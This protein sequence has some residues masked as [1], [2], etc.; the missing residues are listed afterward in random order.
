[1]SR[2]ETLFGL[3]RYVLAILRHMEAH[4]ERLKWSLAEESN[5]LTLT[6]TWNFD[7]AKP[8]KT[9]VAAVHATLSLI[10]LMFIHYTVLFTTS[11]SYRQLATSVSSHSACRF[12]TAI[13]EKKTAVYPLR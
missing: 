5:Q 8:R 13:N 11:S 7:S 10:M 6:L 3:P 1:M 12:K 9:K 2:R 4:S